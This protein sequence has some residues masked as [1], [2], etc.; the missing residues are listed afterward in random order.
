MSTIWSAVATPQEALTCFN[1]FSE[2]R[3]FLNKFET[4]L[5]LLAILGYTPSKVEIRQKL[6]VVLGLSFVW[7]YFR[8]G[9]EAI[10][11]LWFGYRYVN[12]S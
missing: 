2:N 5:A 6:N 8:L 7:K 12:S 11:F 10:L 1:H 4:K 9:P 3:G